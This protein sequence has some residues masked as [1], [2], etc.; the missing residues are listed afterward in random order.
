MKLNDFAKDYLRLGLRI[1]KHINGYVEYYY[2]PPEIKD[3]I[4]TENP[5]S[6]KSLLKDCRQLYKRLKKQSFEN[7]RYKFLD[8]TLS[9]IET[10]LR[11]LNGEY[12]PYLEYVQKVFDFKPLLYNDDYFYD[13]IAEADR[14]YH[15]TGD[16][17][18]RIRDYAKRRIIL[19]YQYKPLFT[20]AIYIVQKRTKEIYPNLLPDNEKVEIAEVRDQSWTFYNWYQGDYN[21]RIDIDIT[22]P[23]YWTHLL[24]IACHEG[25]PGHHTEASVK[26]YLLYRTKGYFE[27]SILLIYTPEMVIHEGIG[28]VAEL[29]LFDAEESAKILL[30]NFCPNT[31]I[32]DSIEKFIDQINFRRKFSR[33]E[34]NL[35]YHKYVDEWSDKELTNY[36]KDFK[37][38]TENVV[39][40]MLKFISD[41]LWAPY[42][43]VYQGERL[44]TQKLGTHPMPQQFF[45]LLSEQTLPSDLN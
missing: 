45:K 2:G 36:A 10:T 21:S 6:P 1:N 17:S 41:D 43:Q 12:F 31:E 44:I 37:V 29:V 24:R 13:L 25:Y 14:I 18:Q 15:G 42:I 19:P 40:S 33:F 22:K 16:L 30:D 26:E 27:S 9:A 34:C 23:H 5:K 38:L 28:E 3:M 8:K 39:K 20:K 35:A 4:N 32:E 7:N 11:V